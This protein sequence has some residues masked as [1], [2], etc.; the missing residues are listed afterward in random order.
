MMEWKD[1]VPT[2]FGCP[3]WLGKIKRRVAKKYLNRWSIGYQLR[4][5]G[6]LIATLDIGDLINDCSGFNGTIIEIDPMYR[7]VAGG[8]VLVDV[9]LTTSNTGCSLT[10]CGVTEEQ[11]REVVEANHLSFLENW[12][13]GEPGKVWFGGLDNPEHKDKI[14]R[15]KR[16]LDILKSG[17]HITDERGRILKEFQ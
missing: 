3:L 12:F 4:K 1:S 7:R 16:K 17:G 13:F 10:S 14:D 9:D 15:A 6:K 2:I 5:R 8:D 11:P